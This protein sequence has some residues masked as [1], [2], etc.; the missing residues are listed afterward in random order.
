VTFT[1]LPDPRPGDP[2]WPHATWPVPDGTALARGAVELRPSSAADG[3]ALFAALDDDE[4]WAH[5]R[6]RPATAED[7]T[8]SLNGAPSVGRFP[9][10]VRRDGMVVGTTSYLEVSAVDARLEIGFTLYARDVWGTEVNPAC[11][12]LLLDWAFTQG[13]GRVQL[14]TDIRNS[15]SQ[16]AIARLGAR[17]EG[18]L[19]RYQRRQDGSVRDTVLFAVLAEDWPGVRAGLLARL[20]G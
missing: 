19:G 1:P 4:V 17:H 13:F 10:T 6:G 8:A 15:R 2:P 5:V 3:P 14:K 7:M 12:F 18:V 9:W 20:G 16:L 11:K